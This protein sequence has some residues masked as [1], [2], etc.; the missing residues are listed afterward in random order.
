[1]WGI[2]S[3]TPY[4]CEAAASFVSHDSR[5]FSCV[6]SKTPQTSA[7]AHR[8]CR[9]RW[10]LFH[11][12][13]SSFSS[14]SACPTVC[15]LRHKTHC[16]HLKQLR[17]LAHNQN[18]KYFGYFSRLSFEIKTQT[19]FTHLKNKTHRWL[20]PVPRVPQYEHSHHPGLP[21]V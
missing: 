15:F 17:T 14:D 20:P 2:L 13:S 5:A 12:S 4:T 7:P 8:W 10:S 9:E 11:S 18:T 1:M 21:L 3:H 19:I 6:W 16:G